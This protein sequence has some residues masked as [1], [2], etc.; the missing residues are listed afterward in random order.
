MRLAH[1]FLALLSISLVA[2]AEPFE[3][4]A[5]LSRAADG[6]AMLVMVDGEIVFEEYPNGGSASR[7]TELASGTKS[8]SG[9]LALCAAEDGLLT[10]DEKISATLTE[11]TNDPARRE[12]TVRQLLSL[13]S[14]IPGGETALSGGRIPSYAE[15]VAIKAETAPGEKFS[16]GPQPFQVFGEVL[17]RKLLPRKESV[18]QY[19]ERRILTPLSIAPA[20]WRKDVD[21]HPHLPSG[22]A[23]TAR[24]WA[25]F[26]EAIRLDAKGILAPGK[27]AACFRGTAANP[28]YGL[29][30]WLPG[31]APVGAKAKRKMVGRG[32]PKEIW[33]AAGAGGQRLVIVPERKLVAVRLA[34]IRTGN[35]RGFNDTEWIRALLDAV[36]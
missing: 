4:A 1:L 10:L 24:D 32:L 29:T 31:E 16:Y 14:G 23:F 15:A 35:L 27:I 12:I 13:T 36:K 19:L 8:F 30:W 17:R 26:G 25:K 20:R 3:A 33:M 2:A 34:P 5:K 6:I 28:A 21:G 18:M 22:A 7:A 9:V 11:W